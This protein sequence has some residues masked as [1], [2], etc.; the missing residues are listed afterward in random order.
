[1]TYMLAMMT[2]QVPIFSFGHKWG[3]IDIFHVVKQMLGE[4]SASF[5]TSNH[6][7]TEK[8]TKELR[9]PEVQ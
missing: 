7:P 4:L 2:M 1:M 3:F 6:K 9:E 5:Y 8:M